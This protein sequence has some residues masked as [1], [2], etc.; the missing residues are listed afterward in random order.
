MDVCWA[1]WGSDG[2]Q[3]AHALLVNVWSEPG[4][5]ASRSLHS[6]APGVKLSFKHCNKACHLAVLLL[7]ALLISD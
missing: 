4:R 7:L 3:V 5:R 2:S 1:A 6:P